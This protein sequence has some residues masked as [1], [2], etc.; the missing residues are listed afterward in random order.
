MVAVSARPCGPVRSSPGSRRASNQRGER[1]HCIADRRHLLQVA[2]DGLQIGLDHPRIPGP[3]HGLFRR[4]TSILPAGDRGPVNGLNR[5]TK[6]S[7]IHRPIPV[8]GSGVIL[9]V[10]T[11]PCGRVHLTP[12]AISRS[13]QGAGRRRSDRRGRVPRVGPLNRTSSSGWRAVIRD[14]IERCAPLR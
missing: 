13:G 12:P 5:A 11:V 6:A 10:H 9:A 1:R 8:S 3:G 4:L 14:I 2:V 7:W